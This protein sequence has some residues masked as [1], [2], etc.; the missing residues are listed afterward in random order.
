LHPAW[1][2]PQITTI[3]LLITGL[4]Y[5][6]LTT[7]M[8]PPLVVGFSLAEAIVQLLLLTA[9]LRLA[10]D[11]ISSNRDATQPD[12]LSN[13]TYQAEDKTLSIGD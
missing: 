7:N 6:S 13:S 11:R 10:I 4:A 8:F 1:I 5:T 3:I 12:T 9:W 2:L